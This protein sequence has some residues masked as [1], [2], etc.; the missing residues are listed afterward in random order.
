MRAQISCAWHIQQAG[1]D[2]MKEG[3]GELIGL[4]QRRNVVIPHSIHSVVVTGEKEAKCIII[5]LV[6]EWCRYPTRV[7]IAP[8]HAGDA[9]AKW[10]ARLQ[11]DRV[12]EE[13]YHRSF[14]W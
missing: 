2:E 8:R 5:V 7:V 1:I 12:G 6:D 3:R 13:F 10:R 11:R 14:R 9:A 4:E